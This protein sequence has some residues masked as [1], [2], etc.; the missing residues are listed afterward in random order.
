MNKFSRSSLL[1]IVLFSVVGCS[2]NN[3][4]LIAIQNYTNQVV[5]RPPGRIPPPPE[6]ISYEAFTYSAASLRGPFAIPLD[7][8]L[9]TLREQS[10]DI[11]PDLNRST[12]ALEVFAIGTLQMRGIMSRNNTIWALVQDGNNDLHYVTEGSYMGRNHGRVV[13]ISEAQINLIEI[14]PN[15]AGGWLERPQTIT[16]NE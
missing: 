15:G 7:V 5:N 11:Q 14:V 9:A 13:T 16:S 1:F 3:E 6:M 10:N 4:A 12:E 2:G 8:S